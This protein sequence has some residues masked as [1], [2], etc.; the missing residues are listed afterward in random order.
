V[1]NANCK[2]KN[3][4]VKREEWVVKMLSGV[5]FDIRE[6]TVHDGP[7]LRTTIF[8]KG[9]PLRCAWCHN[10]EG[11]S[12]EPEMMRSPAGER[13]VG[14]R[15]TSKVLAEILNRQ[16]EI[17]RNGEGGVTFSGGEAL[18]Q[19]E[20]VA[21][22]ID[23]L[24]GIH[25]LLDTSGFASESAFRLVVPRCDM[26][27][28]DLK[29]VDAEQHRKYTGADNGLILRNLKI[30]SE[31]DVPFVI[32]VPLVPGVTDTDENLSAIATVSQNLRGLRQVDLLPYNKAAGGKYASVGKTFSPPYD[33]NRALNINTT[34]FEKAGVE[35]HVA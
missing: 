30:L 32:R 6:F 29:L 1:Q 24:A 9:C 19:A 28:Y 35:V 4:K 17:L 27:Y 2:V 16:A 8:L 3:A 7:G 25:V 14:Q 33:E 15:Y 26:V 34:F 10:P 13:L 20:F 22:T 31:L 23:Q 18:M 21:E 5:I 12:P 11:M